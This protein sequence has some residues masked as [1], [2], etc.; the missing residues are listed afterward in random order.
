V[1][2]ALTNCIKHAGPARATVRLCYGRDDLE[3]QVLDDG[4]G[5]VGWRDPDRENGGH[6]MIGMRE[7]V[8][9]FGGQLDVGPRPGGGFRVDARLPLEP[10][11]P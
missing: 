5:V 11:G 7:R 8:A 6:G 4:R 10:V 1:Q 2:E 3:L 9:V